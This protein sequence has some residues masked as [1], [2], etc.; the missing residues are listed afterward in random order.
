MVC[1][2]PLGGPLAQPLRPWPD[3]GAGALAGGAGIGGGAHGG[4][5]GVAAEPAWGLWLGWYY[6]QR[7]AVGGGLELHDG[8][9]PVLRA[10]PGAGTVG[11]HH[12]A[13]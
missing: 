11:Q 7:L 13:G 4:A 3:V 9:H 5:G 12:G 10:E 8:A 1:S 2:Q 6:R